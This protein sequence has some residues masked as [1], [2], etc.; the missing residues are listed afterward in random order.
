MEFREQ[1]NKI[2]QNHPN[3]TI[4][5]VTKTRTAQEVADLPLIIEH[6][7][8]NKVQEAEQ[9]FQILTQLTNRKFEK[10]LIGRLQTNK[11]NKAIQ[12][13][14]YIQS[15]D[16]LDLAK[17]IDQRC[18]INKKEIKIFLQI[19]A[20]EDPKK[21]GLPPDQTLL[22]TTA[23]EIQ[24]NYT[25]LKIVGLMTILENSKDNLATQKSFMQMQNLFKFLNKHI[26]DL[27]YLSMGMSDDYQ[28]ALKAGS[29]MIR[30][31]RKLFE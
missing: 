28:E 25:N 27:K 10:H 8:E 26:L 14:D 20:S 22:L 23:K 15:V 13:F 4:L 3:L 21:Q 6:I 16:S 12:L 29:N 19:N 11:I 2:S 30:I 7:G 9:K 17:K 5:A 24:E 18:K 1:I 31:G